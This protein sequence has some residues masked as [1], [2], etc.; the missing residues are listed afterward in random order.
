MRLLYLRVNKFKLIFT[1]NSMRLDY[2]KALT[3]LSYPMILPRSSATTTSIQS[4]Q[5]LT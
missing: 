4:V 5:F 3:P 2:F 1:I